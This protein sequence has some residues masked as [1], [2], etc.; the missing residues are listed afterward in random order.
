[1]AEEERGGEA[2]LV[3]GACWDGSEV[4]KATG[5]GVEMEG[6][7]GVVVGMAD[8]A[9]VAVAAA[10]QARVNI[11]KSAGINILLRFNMPLFSL[12]APGLLMT[13][14]P[15]AIT[16]PKGFLSRHTLDSNNL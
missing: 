3:A 2:V 8:A 5:A 16:G 1:V 7:L 10:P 13:I 15:K 11:A 9:G 14:R 4:A 6:V 12:A